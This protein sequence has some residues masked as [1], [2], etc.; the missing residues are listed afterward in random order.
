M[1]VTSLLRFQCRM[2][3]V[4]KHIRLLFTS[5]F[6]YVS[7]HLRPAA[8]PFILPNMFSCPKLAGQSVVEFYYIAGR[9]PSHFARH[10]R[11]PQ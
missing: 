4:K 8:G 10:S 1:Y 6:T 9:T 11:F 5:L 3:F 2:F 7:L